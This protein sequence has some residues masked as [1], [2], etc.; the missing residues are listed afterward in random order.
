MNF[1]CESFDGAALGLQLYQV[2]H[3]SHQRTVSHDQ[4]HTAYGLPDI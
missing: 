1:R 2:M 3:K 4:N